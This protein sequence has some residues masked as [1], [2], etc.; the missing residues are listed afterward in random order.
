MS[1]KFNNVIPFPTQRRE[2]NDAQL[3]HEDKVFGPMDNYNEQLELILE[4]AKQVE[5][6]SEDLLNLA[7]DMLRNPGKYE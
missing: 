1:I 4:Q 6:L 2:K 3:R 5:K 7:E